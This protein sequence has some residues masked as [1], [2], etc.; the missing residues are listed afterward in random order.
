MC[1]IG[2]CASPTHIICHREHLQKQPW[3][4]EHRLDFMF[5]LRESGS[6]ENPYPVLIHYK[7]NDSVFAITCTDFCKCQSW[8]SKPNVC[9][10]TLRAGFFSKEVMPGD[11]L[12]PMSLIALSSSAT[13]LL[14]RVKF[15]KVLL[16]NVV[17][18][19]KPLWESRNFS[20]KIIFLGF[21]TP[22]W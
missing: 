16:Q 4:S 12:L 11:N 9:F 1:I 21:R 22:R 6:S 18:D 20:R 13:K 2:V 3:F 15:P 17:R 19:T 7:W 5:F 10:F 8:Y 14:K